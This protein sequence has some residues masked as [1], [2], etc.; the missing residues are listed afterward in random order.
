MDR[1]DA[2]HIVRAPVRV[3]PNVT[4]DASQRPV[5]GVSFFSRARTRH[6]HVRSLAYLVTAET[7]VREGWSTSGIRLADID[8]LT[9][10]V[11]RRSWT[12]PHR[13]G[14]R[15]WNWD[16]LIEHMPRRAAVIPLAVW[17]GETLCG[18]GRGYLTRR[19]LGG[20]NAAVLQYVEAC[21]SDH[22]LRG[23]VIQIAAAAAEIYGAEFGARYLRLMNPDAALLPYYTES[24]GFRVAYKG[25]VAR[26][27]EREI[28]R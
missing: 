19:R 17:H 12:G 18:L 7:A 22:P 9:L 8:P 28:L 25:A 14:A 27:C 11:W 6:A 16:A 2:R 1:S 15:P 5:P 20:R 21:P 23:R 13:H 10:D 24:F 3:R 4:I 26:Y